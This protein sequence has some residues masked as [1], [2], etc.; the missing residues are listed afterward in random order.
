[1]VKWCLQKRESMNT[2]MSCCHD[3]DTFIILDYCS[4]GFGIKINTLSRPLNTNI[5]ILHTVMI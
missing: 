1:M 5:A 3:Q 2:K 4:Y